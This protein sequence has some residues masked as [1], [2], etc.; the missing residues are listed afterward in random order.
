[1]RYPGGKRLFSTLPLLKVSLQ[2]QYL[3]SGLG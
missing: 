1:M 3:T 2:R